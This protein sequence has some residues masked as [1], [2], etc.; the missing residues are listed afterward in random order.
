MTSFSFQLRMSLLFFVRLC[1]NMVREIWVVHVTLRSYKILCDFG[2]HLDLLGQEQG[3]CIFFLY[4]LICRLI[5]PQILYRVTSYFQLWLLNKGTAGQR[6]ITSSIYLN[7]NISS[8]YCRFEIKLC[9]G[10]SRTMMTLLFIKNHFSVTSGLADMTSLN[11]QLLNDNSLILCWIES[12]CG[13]IDLSCPY[14][15]EII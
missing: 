5:H 13:Q 15:F 3:Q 9:F 1:Q 7:W 10:K 12:K 6:G 14:D 2:G 11:F 8:I 4:C